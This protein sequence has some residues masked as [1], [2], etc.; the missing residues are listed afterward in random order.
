MSER[1]LKMFRGTLHR[2]A[3]WLEQ[4]NGGVVVYQQESEEHSALWL[5]SSPADTLRCFNYPAGSDPLQHYTLNSNNYNT[6]PFP[7]A[8]RVFNILLCD[9]S[10]AIKI[11]IIIAK[12]IFVKKINNKN[13]D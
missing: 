13:S 8:I 9:T 2:V 7:P 1:E 3:K 5:S 4:D 11:L 6:R 10:S 12:N